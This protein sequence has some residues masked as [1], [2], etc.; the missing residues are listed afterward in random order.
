MAGMFY[1]L[2][3]VIEKMQ[4]TKE[5]IDE[6]VRDGRLREFRDGPNLLFKVDEVEALMSDTSFMAAQQPSAPEPQT[7]QEPLLIDLE[8]AE[9]AAEPPES[10]EADTVGVPGDEAIAPEVSEAPA[11]PT[12]EAAADISGQE[13]EVTEEISLEPESAEVES[14]QKGLSDADTILA[15]EGTDLLSETDTAQET[16]DDLLGATKAESDQ[17]SLEQIEEDINLDTFGS[18]SGLL[19]LSLQADDTSLG[20]VLDEIYTS[21]GDEEK[22]SGEVPAASV[23]AEAEE[24]ISGEGAG[25]EPAAVAMVPMY[26]EPQPDAISNA[27]GLVLFVPLL[28]VIYTAI[29]VLAGFNNIMPFVLEQ[30]K[31]MIWYIAL[32]LAVL[33]LVIIGVPFMLGGKAGAKPK[34]KAKAKTKKAKTKKAPQPKPDS[35]TQ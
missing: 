31:G 11:P 13:A 30:T 25:A 10:T 33:A 18:G 19:D 32:G 5:R 35:Q 7:Q 15:D 23:A 8:P 16:G 21:E 12:A 24:I 14:S 20:G 6:L 3:E 4:L 17:A 34:I 26:A 1:S 22:G 27:F 29:V 9:T 28:V 2:Q